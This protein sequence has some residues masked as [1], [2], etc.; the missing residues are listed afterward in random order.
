MILAGDVGATKTVLGLFT[1]EGGP[2]SPLSEAVFPSSRYESLGEIAAEFLSHTLPEKVDAACFGVAGPVR[3]G[4]ATVTNLPWGMDQRKLASALDIPLVKL[5]NDLHATAM[6]L[7]VLK[8]YDLGTLNA[9]RPEPGGALAVIAPGTG[10]GQAFL[11]WD[12]K[13][14]RAY[15]SEG[16]HGDFA[17][18][19]EVQVELLRY[20]KNR[21][22]HVSWEQ[23]CSGLG[24]SNIFD[25]LVSTGKFELP[26]W[27]SER[28]SS[29]GDR[30]PV[31]IG[32]ALGETPPCPLTLE[33]LRI[34]VS[35]LGAEAGN[36]ALKTM[37]TGGLYLGG[38]IPPRILTFLEDPSFLGSFNAKGRLRDVMRDI[39]VQVILNPKAALTGAATEALEMLRSR[40]T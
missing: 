10:L 34:F 12:G 20:M 7:P 5:V 4:R 2:A 28:L 9:G 19:D 27:L 16:G 13:A 32:S 6:A 22:A 24:I 38:G 35:I 14:Y 40:G 3:D 39:P 26:S 29:T 33:T 30:T 15:P 1:G 8:P 23:V 11:V 17:P 21:R 36:L 37:S 25:F 18:A 31:I